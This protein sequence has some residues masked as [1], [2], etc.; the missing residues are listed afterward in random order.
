MGKKF[1]GTLLGIAMVGTMLVGCTGWET[2]LGEAKDAEIPVIIVD[3]M[4]DVSDEVLYTCWV[5]SDFYQEGLD[6]LE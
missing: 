1:L 5:G 6:A 3:R 4:I 2:V